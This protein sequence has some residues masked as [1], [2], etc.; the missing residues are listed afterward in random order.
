MKMSVVLFLQSLVGFHHLG[1]SESWGRIQST[2]PKHCFDSP[3]VEG[4]ISNI[5]TCLRGGIPDEI[6]I[7]LPNVSG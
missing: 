7:D 3:A 2:R 4:C 5:L 1:G 6:M